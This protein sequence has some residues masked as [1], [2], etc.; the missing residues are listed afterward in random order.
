VNPFAIFFARFVSPCA[1]SSA[2]AL[3]SYAVCGTISGRCAMSDRA[4]FPN[5][6]GAPA[7][8][9]PGAARSAAAVIAWLD[10][11]RLIVADRGPTPR[12]ALRGAGPGFATDRVCGPAIL[13]SSADQ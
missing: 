11:V 8:F 12:C 3:T 1:A 2:A 6:P 7:F 10:A 5:L 9:R 4:A 13:R